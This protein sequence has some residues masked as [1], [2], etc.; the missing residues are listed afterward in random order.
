MWHLYINTAR[1]EPRAKFE[2]KRDVHAGTET[3]NA[4]I[5]PPIEAVSPEPSPTTLTSPIGL[6]EDSSPRRSSKLHIQTKFFGHY[7]MYQGPDARKS[8]VRARQ[9]SFTRTTPKYMRLNRVYIQDQVYAQVRAFAQGCKVPRGRS[10]RITM[11]VVVPLSIGYQFFQDFPSIYRQLTVNAVPLP[12][13]DGD[14]CTG[15]LEVSHSS[16]VN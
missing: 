4:D 8:P 16:Q 3:V 7:S 6:G 5:S 10:G 12:L 11:P 2:M 14:F 1:T 9:T 15:F 13:E